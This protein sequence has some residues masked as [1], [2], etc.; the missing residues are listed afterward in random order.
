MKYH[1]LGKKK[2]I[3]SR[4]QRGSESISNSNLRAGDKEHR[5]MHV[6]VKILDG[7]RTVRMLTTLER[8]SFY[9]KAATGQRLI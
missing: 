5:A 8:G 7:L 2:N 3:P 6:A 1:L 4:H 9:A